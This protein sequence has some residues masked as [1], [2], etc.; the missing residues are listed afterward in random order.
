MQVDLFRFRCGRWGTRIGQRDHRGRGKPRKA[1]ALA[2]ARYRLSRTLARDLDPT[3]FENLNLG[4]LLASPPPGFDE[5]LAVAKIMDFV[6]S[7]SDDG[8]SAVAMPGG[9]TGGPQRFANVVIDTAPTGHTLR[10]LAAPELLDRS[11]GKA[12]AVKRMLDGASSLVKSVLSFGQAPSSAEGGEPSLTDK[13]ESARRRLR[14]FG[15]LLKD[16]E[17]TEFVAVTIPTRWP[18]ARRSRWHPR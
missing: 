18:S 6:D 15:R 4:D 5:V 8:D 12:L 14:A 11:L 3:V 10:L 2:R 16:A 1:E 17:A 7:D 9:G 13:I